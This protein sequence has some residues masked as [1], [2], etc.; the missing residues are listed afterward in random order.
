MSDSRVSDVQPLLPGTTVGVVGGGQLGRYFVLEARRLGYHTW[1]LDPDQNAPAMQLAEHCLIADYDDEEALKQ[2][3]NACDAVTVEFENVPAKSLELLDALCR[4][5]PTAAS[6]RVAQ[7]RDLEKKTAQMHGLTPV[8]YATILN[9]GDIPV[10]VASVE[11]PAILKTSRLGYD[12]KGQHVCHNQQELMD[13]FDAVGHAECVLEHR[14][15][16]LA[17]VSVVLARR[18]D[19]QTAVFPLSRNVHVG[20]VLSTSTVPSGLDNEILSHAENLA[21]KL[22]DGLNYV[23]VLAVEFFIDRSGNV[24]FNEMAPRPHNSGHYTL[25]ATVTSQFEQQLRALCN[26][27]LGDT[28]LLSPVCMTNVLGDVWTNGDPDWLAVLN[29]A[30]AHLHLYGK[31]EARGGRK[32]GHINCLAETSEQALHLAQEAQS[33]LARE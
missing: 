6:I 31:S 28:M 5:A 4:V 9:V 2:L 15:D 1:V 18:S 29:Q 11:F 27:P 10:A 21:R 12:G 7:D 26:L 13:A 33:T 20:G 30:G 16:L 22:A 19:G 32:M 17:E 24:L 23:G 8:P 14:I 3:G 25:D